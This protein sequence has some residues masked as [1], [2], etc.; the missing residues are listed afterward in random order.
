[1]LGGAGNDILDGG[2]G[3]DSLQGGDGVD[4]LTGGAGDDTLDL[5]TD[6][7][8]MVSDSA[9]GGTGNDTFIIDQS[10]LTSGFPILDGGVGGSDTLKFAG[11]TSA[12][13][14]LSSLSGFTSVEVLD[15]SADGVNSNIILS[16]LG[17]QGLVD[18]GNSSVLNIKLSA[19]DLVSISIVSGETWSFNNTSNT[20]SFIQ[21]GVT[22]AQAVL[23]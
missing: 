21:N 19:N 22:V 11:S 13:L 3:A 5:N 10:K 16:A 14:D 9:I 15:V 8:S 1:V 23:L 18:N 17:I 20:Y 6:N 2:D 12:S 7:A 4:S